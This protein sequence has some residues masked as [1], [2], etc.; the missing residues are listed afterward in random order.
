PAEPRA[1]EAGWRDALA[2]GR[3]QEAGPA[4]IVPLACDEG[5]AGLI[6][7]CG[8]SA[9][10]VASG[11]MQFWRGLGG[12]VGEAVRNAERHRATQKE[13]RRFRALGEPRAA[14]TH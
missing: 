11:G 10:D 14:V 6:E 9:S 7:I 12:L 2:S 8:A 1:M 5:A 13:L 3:P 4:F